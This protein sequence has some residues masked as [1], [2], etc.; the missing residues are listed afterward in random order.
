MTFPDLN[1]ERFKYGRT[2]LETVV[3]QLRFNP[4]LKIGQDLPVVFQDRVR[5]EF[6]KFIKEESA[7]LQIGPG[8]AAELLPTPPAVWR[9]RTEDEA[10]TASLGVESL[11]LE[12]T[13]YRDYPD[14]ERRLSVAE[15][16]LQEAHAIDH[17]VR[18]GLRYINAFDKAE[19][20]GGWLPRL[21]PQ[22]LG[23]M[24]DPVLGTQVAESLQIF[25][26]EEEDWTIRVR[27][28]TDDGNYNLDIDHA[29]EGRVE[30]ADVLERLRAFNRGIYQMFRWAISDAMHEEMEPGPHE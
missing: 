8:G 5:H 21:N 4:I 16:A 15:Q 11:S 10:W 1:Y 18:V 17:Y 14:F 22:L 25:K 6:P 13:E 7:G 20:P 2:G 23:P 30:A 3:C 27:H 19:F 9:F 12:T 28:G 26:L 29:T 24:A